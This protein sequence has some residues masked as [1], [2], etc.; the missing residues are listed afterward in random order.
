MTKAVGWAAETE[1]GSSGALRLLL[2]VYR[3]LGRRIMLYFRWPVAVYF[4]VR[5]SAH[6]QSSLNFLQAVH[7]DE[8]GRGALP[9]PPGQRQV[10]THLSEFGTNLVD[11][12]VLWAG[13][14][15]QVPIRYD[16]DE[17]LRPLVS[18]GTGAILM[19][20]HLGSF[21]MLRGL[22]KKYDFVVNVLM[23]TNHAQR[24]NAFFEALDPASSLR[25]LHLDPGSVRTA[26]EIRAC[27]DRGELVAILAD[28]IDPGSRARLHEVPFLGREALFPIS[29]FLLATT[30]DCPLL[31]SLCVRDDNPGYQAI[32]RPLRPIEPEAPPLRDRAERHRAAAAALHQYVRLME[33]VCYRHP[34]QWC[35]FYD[36]WNQGRQSREKIG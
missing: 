23:F 19:G 35:N 14:V 6:R 5:S 18:R 17:Y 25:V 22:A 13:G 7:A 21:D 12:M 2:L 29:P 1:R 32:I 10:L 27:I 3:L 34:Y 24:I 30:L 36:F 28:R 11:R 4:F 15:D 8:Q 33:Q 9:S 31:L 20:A 26:F 16:G